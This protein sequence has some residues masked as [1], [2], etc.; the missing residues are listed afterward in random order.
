[1]H[2]K[3]PCQ[4]KKV[5]KY[6]IFYKKK[7]SAKNFA[8]FY[9][10]FNLFIFSFRIYLKIELPLLNLYQIYFLFSFL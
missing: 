5:E 8:E 7:E 6:K 4:G 9:F 2:F 1:M 10:S 3:R